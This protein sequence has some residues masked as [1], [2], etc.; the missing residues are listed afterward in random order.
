MADTELMLD[1]GQANELK[2]A[3]RRAGYTNAE[4][5]K[6]S[7]GDLL[8]DLLPLIRAYGKTPTVTVPQH[9][10]DC[11]VDPS[12]PNGLTIHSHTKGGQLTFD[13]SKITLYWSEKQK[14]SG[15]IEGYKFLKELANKSPLNV[16]V[17]DY[18]L[19]NPNLIPDSWKGKAV[20]FFGTVY[21]N[22]DGR[23]YVRY[24]R[25]SGE[26]GYSN[27]GW[28]DDGWNDLSP[29]VLRASN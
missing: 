11:D 20:F 16:C 27:Y 14:G 10:I 3:F 26:Q 13:S 8:A 25:W 4:I 23:L 2:L 18:L 7:E 17:L 28:L 9:L 5:K 6:M 12:I 19:K 15:I 22:S 21:R 24:L 29:A 1:V